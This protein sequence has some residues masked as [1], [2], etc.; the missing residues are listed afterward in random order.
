[1]DTIIQEYAASAKDRRSGYT[2]T[3]HYTLI[4]G[5]VGKFASDTN[6][7]MTIVTQSNYY[8]FASFYGEFGS[9]GSGDHMEPHVQNY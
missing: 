3:A 4:V 7:R 8:E 1:M 6:F 5:L 2:H 9:M